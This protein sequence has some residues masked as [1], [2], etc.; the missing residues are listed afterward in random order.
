MQRNCQFTLAGKQK[1]KVVIFVKNQ[2]AGTEVALASS[3]PKAARSKRAARTVGAAA[4]SLGIFGAF[5]LPAYAMEPA[6]E[7]V[8]QASVQAQVLSAAETDAAPLPV[9]VEEVPVEEIVPEP[10]AP[11]IPA[12]VETTADEGEE[13]VAEEAA[14]AIP[15]GSGAPGI[16]N[17]A[18]AQLG[19]FMDCTDLAQNSLAAVGLVQAREAGGPDLGVQSFASFGAV[20]PYNP[21][22]V[23]PGD[24]LVWPGAP[25]VAVAVGGGQAVHGGWGGTVVLAGHQNHGAYPEYIVR[26]G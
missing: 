11:V 18:L 2:N 15:A 8:V 10:P 23:A 26:V 14:P 4:L 20:Y 6:G 5:A 9:V 13:A 1:R 24:L 3:T 17:A 19:Q 16:A 22:S 25:H 12:V 21:L 7:E